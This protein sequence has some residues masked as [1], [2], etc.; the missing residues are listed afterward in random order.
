MLLSSEIQRLFIGK[1]KRF[2]DEFYLH[3]HGHE[4]PNYNVSHIETL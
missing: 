4:L 3:R 2:E 1:Y